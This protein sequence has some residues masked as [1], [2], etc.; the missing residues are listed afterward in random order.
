MTPTATERDVL[1]QVFARALF[2]NDMDALYAVVT[3]NF[4]WRYHDGLSIERVLTGRDAIR[5]HIEERKAFFSSSRFHDVAYHHL[6]DISFM[7]FRV[8]ETVRLTGEQREQ[9][10]IERYSFDNGKLATK[11]VYRKPIAG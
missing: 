10:G 3:E 8:S 4:V 9:Q 5:N 6:P 11:D 1:F 2:K 7:T